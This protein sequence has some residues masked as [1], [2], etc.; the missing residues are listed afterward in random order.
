MV[1]LQEEDDARSFVAFKCSLACFEDF[2]V[3]GLI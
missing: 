2:S 1:V 3:P